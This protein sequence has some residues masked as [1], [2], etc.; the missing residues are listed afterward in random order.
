[1]AFSAA[2][3]LNLEW[4]RTCD[5]GLPAPD[6]V[7]YLDMP[8]EEAAQVILSIHMVSHALIE[9]DVHDSRQALSSLHSGHGY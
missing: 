2:K 3:G 4:C 7:I 6:C 8:V 9:Y 1:V 5:K